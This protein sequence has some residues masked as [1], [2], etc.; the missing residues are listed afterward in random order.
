MIYIDN[1]VFKHDDNYVSPVE[2]FERRYLKPTD[3]PTKA[4]YAFP[5]SDGDVSQARKAAVPLKTIQDTSGA[6]D[7]GKIGASTE[8]QLS[9]VSKSC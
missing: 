1:T 6:S 9:R 2:E 4:R 8:M 3:T 5:K 7:F